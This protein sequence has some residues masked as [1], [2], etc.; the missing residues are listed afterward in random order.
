M[1]QPLPL[2]KS[3]AS[4][5]AAVTLLPAAAPDEDIH[6][7]V[8][9]DDETSALILTKPLQKSG[10][11]VSHARNG[12]E[13]WAFLNRPQP[14]QIALLD[15]MMPGYSGVELCA[16]IAQRRDVFVYTV[17]ITSRT[18]PGDMLAGLQAGAH[19]FLLTPVNLA[20]FNARMNVAIRLLRYER[21][22]A[23]KQVELQA[24]ALQMES[25]AEARAQQLVHA[26]RIAT[27]G[28][29]SA[30]IIHEIKNPLTYLAGN[31]QTLTRYWNRLKPLLPAVANDA[32][33]P[34]QLGRM[35]ENIPVLLQG[36]HDGVAHISRI[37]SGL[38]RFSH[39]GTEQRTPT[40][41]RTCVDAAVDL[42]QACWKY[43]AEVQVSGGE[44]LAPL[45]I[46]EQEIV[47]V[48]LNLIVNASDALE[49]R[50]DGGEGRIDVRLHA[51]E[52][53]QY[54][55]VSDNGPGIPED[56]L[57]RIW[58]PFFTTKEQG[59]GT[60]LGLAIS[61]GIVQEH[62]G[63]MTVR[64]LPEGGARFTISIPTPGPSAELPD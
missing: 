1:E 19:E 7:L 11:R 53:A 35:S 10:Y 44:E 22:L 32:L 63:T 57:A 12:T 64:N 20:E 6:I 4:H 37:A 21:D 27:L 60:G 3:E 5:A 18:Q 26:D 50:S 23:R 45:V 52:D 8:A 42:S 58:N 13:A 38:S 46:N 55:Q 25:L 34:D 48:L 29:M 16:M 62:G 17:L 39:A 56:V 61:L 33:P 41:L 2:A 30:G 51:D 47:Q 9:D 59:R 14:P 31:A 54:I 43:H 28:V 36:I 40:T 24:Y 15:W 49:Q